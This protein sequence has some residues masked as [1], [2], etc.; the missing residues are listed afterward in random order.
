VYES[1]LFRELEQTIK[2]D[3]RAVR[4]TNFSDSTV[5]RQK[6]EVATQREQEKKSIPPE[7]RDIL[8]LILEGNP[9][10]I[11]YVLSN[12][13]LMQFSDERMRNLAQF[14]LDVYDERGTIDALSIVNEL[15]EQDLKNLVT[16]LVLSRYELSPGWHE[17]EKEIDEP[18]P[19]MIARDAIVTIRRKAIQKEMEEN[20]R[21]LKEASAHQNDATPYLVKQHELLLMLK[22]LEQLKN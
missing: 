15:P 7:E 11:R 16:D 2:Q 22:Q 3:K 10:V 12:I 9:D 18:D 19:M 6:A 13:S 8:K 1:L 14:V 5:V 21:A 20:Q 17:M 4:S